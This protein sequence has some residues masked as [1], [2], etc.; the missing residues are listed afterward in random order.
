MPNFYNRIKA[1]KFSTSADTAVEI[2]PSSSATPNFS[3]DAG[4]KLNWSSGSATADTN[5]YRSSANVLKTD[6]SF[7]V[8]SGKTYK[9]DGTDVLSSTSLGSSVVG[10]S[11]TSVGSLTGLTAATPNFTGP[12]T[13]SGAATFSSSVTV[14]GNLTVNGTTT[15]VNSITLTVDDKNIELGS[16]DTPTNTTADGG[17]ITLKG[18]TDKTITWDNSATP[19]WNLSENLNLVSGKTVKINNTDVL[20]PSNILGSATSASIG[21]S[22][23]T[24]TV[25]NGLVIKQV[26]ETTTIDS[27]TNLSAL[28]TNVDVLTSSIYYFSGTPSANFAINIRGNSS[29]TNLNDILSTGQTLTISIIVDRAANTYKLSTVNINGSSQTI[30]WFG[31]TAPSAGNALDIYSITVLKTAA[32]TYKVFASQAKF[33]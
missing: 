9:I 26:I 22:T 20:T 30:N 17:G 21:A 14:A 11:L 13:S 16:V 24:T 19:S 31:G 29:V 1:L 12:L 27:T 32:S 2:G 6:D 18:T 4:G 15:T 10:S 28:A 5:L 25:N 23:G 7:D 3:I 33:A 8:A